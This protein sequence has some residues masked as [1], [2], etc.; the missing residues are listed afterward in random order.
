MTRRTFLWIAPA[1]TSGLL[2]AH[3]RREA[4]AS[5]KQSPDLHAAS[6][7]SYRL[8]KPDDRFVLPPALTEVSGLSEVSSTRVA[9]V[10][11]EEGSVYVYDLESRRVVRRIP[12]APPGDYEGIAAADGGFFVLRSDG[13]LYEVKDASGRP[14]PEV[15]ELA[16]PTADNEGL[17]FDAK[18]R[19]LLIAPKSRLGKGK[20]TKFDRA[21]FAFDLKSRTLLPDPVLEWSV[22]DVVEFAES[23]GLPLPASSRKQ[24]D[25]RVALQLLPSSLAVHPITDEIF[26]LSA[27][28]SVLISLS[29]SGAVTGYALLD[30][31]LHRQPEGITFT[32]SGDM[33]IANE[34][35]GG[36]PL[37]YLFKWRAGKP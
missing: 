15:Y 9:C 8:A 6:S 7:F 25:M 27:A 21:V 26:V 37:L 4:A 11:D 22:G 16:L 29:R 36:A 24:G 32:N 12:F 18:S 1:I 28:D 10:Q 33:L 19:R 5:K 17:A 30:R 20:E 2:S 13:V 23:K 34:G 3:C 31:R 35:A 14:A